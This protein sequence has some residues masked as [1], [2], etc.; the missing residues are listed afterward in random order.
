MT[1]SIDGGV[2][3]YAPMAHTDGTRCTGLIWPKG[4]ES[5]KSI[6]V[7]RRT[8]VRLIMQ[9]KLIGNAPHNS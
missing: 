2:V 7:E 8:S 1:P 6:N 4:L 3:V 5:N 9:I